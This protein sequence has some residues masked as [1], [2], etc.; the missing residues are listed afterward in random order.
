MARV[1]YLTEKAAEGDAKRALASDLGGMNVFRVLAHASTSIVPMM[2]L[3]RAIL[4]KQRLSH[5][6]REL[7]ILLAM[8]LEDGKYEWAQHIEI[9]L[10]VGITQTEIDAVHDLR[11]D[12][13]TFS[14]AERAW[15][16][17]GRQVVEQVRV[18][19]STFDAV[20]AQA[21]EA[22][23]V[24]AIIAMSFYMTLAR[25]TEALEVDND[26]VQGMKVLA[27]ASRP[28]VAKGATDS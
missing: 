14:V 28:A 5:R 6:L 7:L 15:L 18:D 2:R 19:Q 21:S 27:F 12:D 8:R 23:I 20:R 16:A 10:G 26:P 4:S 9:A 3:G 25:I 11:L 22:E 1:T 24:E 17:F 13:A